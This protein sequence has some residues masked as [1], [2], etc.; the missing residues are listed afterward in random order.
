[1]FYFLATPNIKR[2]RKI[3]G[4]DGRLSNDEDYER[5][6]WVG[7]VIQDEKLVL[8]KKS[9]DSIFH[10]SLKQT[11]EY[12]KLNLYIQSLPLLLLL[13]GVVILYYSIINPL[14]NIILYNIFRVQIII[15]H[16]WT[17]LITRCC[18]RSN[19]NINGTSIILDDQVRQCK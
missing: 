10:V 11:Y 7:L 6:R 1:M 19:N 15:E 8:S 13:H 14:Y 9:I 5:Q 17:S 3:V 12:S 4:W 16:L 18:R 2:N